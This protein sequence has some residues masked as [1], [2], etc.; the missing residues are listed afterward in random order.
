MIPKRLICHCLVVDCMDVLVAPLDDDK[1][2]CEPLLF[3]EIVMLITTI[4]NQ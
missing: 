4:K 1:S 3:G 2:S